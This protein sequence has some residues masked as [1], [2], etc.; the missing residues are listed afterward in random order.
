MIINGLPGLS[1]PKNFCKDNIKKGSSYLAPL[2]LYLLMISL[3]TLI[4]PVTPS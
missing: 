1:K 3:K 4:L 2:P